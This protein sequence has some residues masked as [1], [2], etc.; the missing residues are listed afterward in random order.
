MKKGIIILVAVLMAMWAGGLFEYDWWDYWFGTY[1][2]T[3][4]E[5]CGILYIP[6]TGESIILERLDAIEKKLDSRSR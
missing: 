1:P 3:E 5:C 6:S 4:L 2:Q